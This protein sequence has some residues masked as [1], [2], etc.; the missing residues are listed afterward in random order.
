MRVLL[1]LNE[2]KPSGAEVMYHAASDLWQKEGCSC[3]ILSTGHR[4][5]AFAPMLRSAGYPI[6]QLPFPA[7]PTVTS[8]LHHILAIYRFLRRNKYDII[9]LNAERAN[10]WY[11]LA[12]RI[13]GHRCILRTFHTS[14]GFTGLL[15]VKRCIQRFVATRL[16]DVTNIAVSP[17]VRDTE[18]RTFFNPTTVLPNWFDSRRFRLPSDVE[19]ASARADLGV[20]PDTLIIT[21]VGNC[22]PAKNHTAIISA[23]AM[24][25]P[26]ELARMLYWHIGLETDES[27]RQLAARLGLRRNVKFLGGIVNVAPLLK[28]SDLYVMPSLYEGFSVAAIE[29]MACGIPAI[30][31]HVRGLSDLTSPDIYWADPTPDSIAQGIRHWAGITASA[32]RNV[33]VRLSLFAHREFG[34]ETGARS[35]IRIYNDA[36]HNSG[37]NGKGRSCLTPSR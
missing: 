36:L 23:L 14:F 6:H 1:V 16:L 37:P 22:G 33:G 24:L 25:T 30:L 18:Q 12:A 8:S 15:R 32:R 9:H 19:Y 4:L 2:L 5:G 35:Y 34:A 28:S 27:E 10:F 21:S 29:A 31:T 11:A 26:S 7:S 20:P 3:E 13:S 17:S